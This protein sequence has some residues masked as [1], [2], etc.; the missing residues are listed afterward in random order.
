MIDKVILK[1]RESIH[2]ESYK[3][4]TKMIWQEWF[5]LLHQENRKSMWQN[6]LVTPDMS[7]LKFV[8]SSTKKFLW[9]QK[10]VERKI[11]YDQNR[12]TESVALVVLQMD[13]MSMRQNQ[14]CNQTKRRKSLSFVITDGKLKKV[15]ENR[16]ILTCAQ[17]KNT[18]NICTIWGLVRMHNVNNGALSL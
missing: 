1:T 6:S 12:T 7:T 10:S 13:L 15:Q 18:P 5:H 3:R 9:V 14:L 2:L 4:F 16:R 8:F 11:V 17:P